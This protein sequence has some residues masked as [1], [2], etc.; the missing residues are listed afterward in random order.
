VIGD[1]SKSSLSRVGVRSFQRKVLQVYADGERSF[2]WRETTD[3]YAILVSEFMLQQTQTTRVVPY[4]A[5]FLGEFPDFDSLASGSKSKLLML[6]QGLGYNRRAL[7]LQRTASIVMD[8]HRGVLPS[9]KEELLPLPGIGAYTAQAI[10]TFAFNQPGVLIETNIRAVYIHHF[11]P[12][13]STVHDRQLVPLIEATLYQSDP[14]TWYYALMDYGVFLKAK[15][16]QIGKRS[17]H[18]VRQ[19]TFQGSH[20]QVRGAVLRELTARRQSTV[21][22]LTRV[23]GYDRERIKLCLEELKKEGFLVQEGRS[24]SLGE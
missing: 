12:P 24:L 9:R 21:A 20:R 13:D 2:Q 17:A 5:R 18:Y 6:W 16:R 10:L 15:Y 7:N 23:L 22:T 4:F 3:P 1:G 14:R 8:R 19:S 11:F